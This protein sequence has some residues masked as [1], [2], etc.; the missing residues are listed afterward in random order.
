[1]LGH[2][3]PTGLHFDAQTVFDKKV[4]HVVTKASSIFVRDAENLLL[5]HVQPVL[6]EAMREPVLIDPLEM[7]VSKV[8]VQGER[9]ISH[10]IAE[11]TDPSFISHVFHTLSREI[12]PEYV[13]SPRID[14]PRVSSRLGGFVPF[15]LFAP[16]VENPPVMQTEHKRRRRR[17][18]PS[19]DSR[20]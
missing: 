16:S 14:A 4:G 1:M 17:T 11:S 2:E 15:V 18:R 7:P 19:G 10:L 3:R 9:D 8:V 13:A 6:A 20:Q 12:Q 5:D